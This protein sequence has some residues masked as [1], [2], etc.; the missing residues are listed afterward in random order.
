L[1]VCGG[2]YWIN[3][4]KGKHKFCG[5]VHSTYDSLEAV[6]LKIEMIKKYLIPTVENTIKEIEI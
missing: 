5:C 2:N 6:E 1:K 3:A 4:A